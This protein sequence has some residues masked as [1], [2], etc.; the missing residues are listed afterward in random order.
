MQTFAAFFSTAGSR[1]VLFSA[2]LACVGFVALRAAYWFASFD[3]SVA[4]LMILAG[5]VAGA[6]F[7]HSA[8]RRPENVRRR[9]AIELC[10]LGCALFAAEVLI[11]AQTP[12]AWTKNPI[13]SEILEREH[14]AERYGVNFD[15]RTVSEVVRDLRRQGVDALPGISRKWPA[16]PQVRPHLPNSFF[17][18]SHVSDATVVE[19]NESGEYLI[20]RTDEFG[21]NNP[22]GL[23]ASG[24]IDVAIVGESSALGH[25]LPDPYSLVGRL[26]SSY[27]RT[28]N[29]SLAGGG[30]LSQL[31]SFREYVERLRPPVVIWVTGNLESP[32]KDDPVLSR[33]LQPGFSQNLFER[34]G[35]IDSAIRRL[36][37]EL[38]A[39]KDRELRS[40]LQ[41]ATAMPFRGVV[42]LPQIRTRLGPAGKWGVTEEEGA[43]DLQLLTQALQQA[44][45][46]VDRWHGQLLVVLMPSYWELVTGDQPDYYAN[47]RMAGAVRAAGVR[48][49]DGGALFARHDDPAALFTFRMA[50]HPNPEG[51]E[52]LAHGVLAELSSS[53]PLKLA[54]AQSK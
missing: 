34:Q 20:Y 43:Q 49:V 3:A 15:A 45:T 23:I 52:I 50:S 26:R 19:C 33:Y 14:V 44:K 16:L 32:E 28:A 30:T 17:P 18:L 54:Q 36:A 51:Y 31:A 35:E 13:A 53:A 12:T 41:Q 2:A 1:V 48:V 6:A 40:E 5:C 22:H 46:A 4:I 29:F 8:L 47:E 9:I 11:T 27:P 38:Q 25:C 7:V 24:Q 37:P 42:T 39:D 10:V 21:F